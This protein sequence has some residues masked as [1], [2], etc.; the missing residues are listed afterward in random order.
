M[1]L[2]RGLLDMTSKP[3][4]TA[5]LWWGLYYPMGNIMPIGAVAARKF[6]IACCKIR[7]LSTNLQPRRIP[8]IEI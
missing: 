1:G 3:D 7:D 6:T 4:I 2:R 8:L 5:N